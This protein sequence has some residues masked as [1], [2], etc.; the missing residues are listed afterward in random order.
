MDGIAVQ[1]D[2]RGNGIGGLLLQNVLDYAKQNDFT[3]I[4]LDVIDDN[5]DAQRLYERW[6]FNPIRTQKFPYLRWF[7]GF[8]GVTTMELCVKKSA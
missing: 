5:P 8:G 2:Y 4:R 6:G 1:E 3:S 7:F